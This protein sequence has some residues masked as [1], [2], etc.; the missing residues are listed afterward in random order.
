MKEKLDI[1]TLKK[2]TAT[3]KDLPDD[4]ILMVMDLLENMRDRFPND[5]GEDRRVQL[6]IYQNELFYR[7][8]RHLHHKEILT[9][10]FI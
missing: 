3:V 8:V 6:K 4:V 9:G 10:E 7:S 5:F 2:M 1:D